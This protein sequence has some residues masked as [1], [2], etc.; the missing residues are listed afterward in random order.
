M[1][2]ANQLFLLVSSLIRKFKISKAVANKP[3]NTQVNEKQ[4][5]SVVE[6]M[7]EIEESYDTCLECKSIIIPIND[8]HPEHG[9]T[10]KCD[11]IHWPEDN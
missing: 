3:V 2:N 6:L 4:E 11:K 9:Y 8:E 5:K 1:E 10:C 7:E